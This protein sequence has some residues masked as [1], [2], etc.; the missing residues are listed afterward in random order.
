[1]S[2]KLTLFGQCQV[3]NFSY[4]AG[5]GNTINCN[6]NFDMIHYTYA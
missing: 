5:H 2:K 1:M 3:E 4:T 6:V